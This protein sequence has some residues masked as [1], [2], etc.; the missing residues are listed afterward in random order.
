[1]KKIFLTLVCVMGVWGGMA[2]S[3]SFSDTSYLRYK[4]FDF[5]AW[6]YADSLHHGNGI[7]NVILY[8]IIHNALLCDDVLQYNFTDNPAGVKVVGL[9]AAIALSRQVPLVYPMFPPEY[10]L[11]YEATPD[12]FE[13]KA[14][15]Q[16]EETDT[17]GRPSY[18]CLL[19]T[20]EIG[21]DSNYYSHIFHGGGGQ[22]DRIFDY[23]FDKPITVYDSFYVGCTSR[24]WL[25]TPGESGTRSGS[26]YITLLTS[27]LP[28]EPYYC[29]SLWKMYHYE[30]YGYLLTNQWHWAMSDQFLEVL[31]IIEVVD[32][33][34]ANAPECPMVGGL[35][36]RGNYTDMVT[37]Q[38]SPD[39]LH[40]EYELSYGR[41]GTPPDAGTIV[42]LRNTTRW[43]FT[44]TSYSDTPMVAY[45]RTVCREYDT[46]RWSGWGSPVYWRLHYDA[47]VDTTH[48]GGIAVPDEDGGLSRFV[49]LMP[50]PASGN[51]V[52][53]S[54]YG[55]DRLEVYDVRGERVLDRKVP[56]R[57]TSAGFSVSG[58]AKGAY[59][60]LVHTP[61][62]VM[63]KRL[64]VK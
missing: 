14:M 58:W 25:R 3:H 53:R 50:N 36:A 4:Q 20:L 16:W 60:V 44:D 31:P 38:W 2:Q 32:T 55:I 26:G 49:R 52:V 35:F 64:L 46:L 28:D 23:Y 21:E 42:S 12:T 13:L 39:S 62:G 17:A 29:P 8:P 54:S 56:T 27:K 24:F 19:N 43:Q 40:N 63:A 34:F 51:V 59:V 33:S 5:D 9:S 11:L 57:A 1:M 6:I 47:P 30:S 45:V 22:F 41:E 48:Q 18:D 61:A 10:L 37:V 7:S 15:V